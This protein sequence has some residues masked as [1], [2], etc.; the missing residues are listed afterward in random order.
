[1]NAGIRQRLAADLARA[2]AEG[3]RLA[4]DV[5]GFSFE[6]TIR[7]TIAS[8]RENAVRLEIAAEHGAPMSAELEQS[9]QDMITSLE[10]LD[11][12]ARTELP[13]LLARARAAFA[14]IPRV[15]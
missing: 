14:R 11:E 13:E 8:H 15:S 9:E 10:T 1:M 7:R 12:Y 6:H 2:I 5:Q 3:E 4:A